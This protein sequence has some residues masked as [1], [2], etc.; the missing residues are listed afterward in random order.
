MTGWSVPVSSVSSSLLAG[1]RASGAWCCK[2]LW[3]LS[4]RVLGNVTEA[5][6]F[7]WP[8]NDMFTQ[9]KHLS[10]A[11]PQGVDTNMLLLM[12]TEQSQDLIFD[13]LIFKSKQNPLFFPE[14]NFI[15]KLLVF[16]NVYIIC[17]DAIFNIAQFGISLM[18]LLKIESFLFFFYLNLILALKPNNSVLLIESFKN[19]WV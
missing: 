16:F 18:F 10:T 8:K 4:S 11:F 12:W 1:C 2:S 17:S 14:W 13:S 9:E 3:L 7:T 6:A 15:R 5:S 19:I